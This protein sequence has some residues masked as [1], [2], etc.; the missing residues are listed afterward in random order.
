MGSGKGEVAGNF[1]LRAAD[2]PDTLCMQAVIT[3]GINPSA[4]PQVVTRSTPIDSK[5]N[6]YNSFHVVAYWKKGD[7]PVTERD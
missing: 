3:D 7:V 5:D 2:A 4:E 6:F 1:V